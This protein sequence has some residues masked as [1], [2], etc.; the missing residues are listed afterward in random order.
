MI[1][2]RSAGAMVGVSILCLTVFA[3][4][5]GRSQDESAS[6]SWYDAGLLRPQ[7]PVKGSSTP[8]D[9]LLIRPHSP[10]KGSPAAPVT[11]VEFLDPEC[12]ACR[13]MHPIVKEVFAEYANQVRLVVRYMPLHRNSLFAASALEEAR[14]AGKFDAALEVLLQKQPAWARHDDP[15]PELIPS[16]LAGIGIDQAKVERDAVISKHRWKIDQDKADGIQLGVRGT[17]TYF[18]NG[19]MLPEL[20][21]Q[22]MKQAIEAALTNRRS[23]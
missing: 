12:E 9:A 21:Y 16:Y 2:K 10:M 5:C 19:K 7:S 15:R 8:N 20:S 6:E 18:I 17:P 13:L 23:Q 11:I 22:A 3:T 4:G 14:E 1:S